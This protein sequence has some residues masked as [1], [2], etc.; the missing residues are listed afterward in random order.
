M[1]KLIPDQESLEVE[2]K[3][4]QR[5]LS[6]DAL[7]D[8]IVAFANTSGGDIYLGVEDDGK[9][10]GL[11]KEHKDSTQLAAFIANKT[12]PPVSARLENLPT[13]PSVLVIHVPK[14]RSIVASSTGK[15]QRRR[16]KADGTPENVPMYPYE[17]NTRL[18]ELSMLDFSAQPV[19]G[20]QYVDLDPLERE[21]LRSMIKAYHGEVMLLELTDEELDQALQFVVTMDGRLI[22]TYT[23]ILLIG[24]KDKLKTLV[25]TAEAAYQML[26]GTE[27]QAN[28]SF[29]LPLLAAIEQIISFIDARNPEREMEMGMFRISIPSFDK[30][31][32]R[33]AVVNAFA[34]R[35]YTR[36][37]RVLV[38][39]DADGLTVTNP[40]G[41]IEG[42]TI[43][44]ILRVEPHGRNPALADALKRIGLA[45]RSGRGVDRIFEGSLKFGRE[46]P[47]YSETTATSVKLFIP[48]GMPD[49]QMVAL[50]AQQQRRT[51]EL[52]P[53]NTLLILHALRRNRRMTLQELLQEVILPESKARATLER[54]TEAGLVEAIGTGRSR[55]YVLSV[56]LYK[57]PEAYV[58]QTDVDQLRY[59][60]LILKLARKKGAVTRSDVIAL[61]HVNPPQAYRLLKHLADQGELIQSGSTR[62]AKY[63]INE[64]TSKT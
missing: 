55:A 60:E 61:L 5:K 35:D 37:G 46:L 9:I 7:I 6:D 51:N 58:R 59:P 38:Q 22:P 21:R 36:L 52:M 57:S 62:G 4:D 10:T 49:E 1:E 64:K 47:D 29:Y 32:V 53:I 33:E 45:E 13:E 39:M 31:A 41:F 63:I 3:S 42:V 25:P 15:I 20:A 2:F 43:Q 17:I 16:I 44:N 8:A 56:K 24:R 19:P 18:S 28:E 34:H 40:G 26:H 27:L 14:S 54:L 50:I 11:H 30:R 48:C 23:G 12:I